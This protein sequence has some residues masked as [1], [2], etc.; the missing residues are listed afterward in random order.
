MGEEDEV[1]IREVAVMINKAMGMTQDI[2][3][4]HDPHVTL[5]HDPH[6]TLLSVLLHGVLQSM[7]WF[8]HVLQFDSSKSDGQLKK[9]ASNAK[10]RKYL[11]D[12]QF[13]PTQQGQL[14]RLHLL[15]L[16]GHIL[17]LPLPF[18]LDFLISLYQ[19]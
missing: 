15:S 17:S 11:P 4:S 3:V 5:S 16:Y 9:T 8:Y 18:L 2:Q 1:S 7:E 13:T 12:F 6:V 10:L 19:L 14:I